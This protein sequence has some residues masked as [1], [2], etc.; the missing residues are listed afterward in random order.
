MQ[1]LESSRTRTER[2]HA[3]RSKKAW[4]CECGRHLRVTGEWALIARVTRVAYHLDAQ[5]PEALRPWSRPRSS[6]APKYTRRSEQ[7]ATDQLPARALKLPNAVQEKPAAALD[8]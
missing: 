3:L 4:D 8:P 7:S 2:G 1:M 6:S 5:Y